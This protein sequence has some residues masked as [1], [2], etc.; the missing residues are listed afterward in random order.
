MNWFVIFVLIT[1]LENLEYPNCT[2]ESFVRRKEKN[3]TIIKEVKERLLYNLTTCALV[4]HVSRRSQKGPS[5]AQQ[6][7]MA[8]TET[9]TNKFVF[10]NLSCSWR[11]NKYFNVNTGIIKIKIWDFV[12]VFVV[13]NVA[14]YVLWRVKT[15]INIINLKN[16]CIL[17]PWFW[18]LI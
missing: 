15:L 17:K 3:S 16:V 4:I 11:T 12:D 18:R 9:F 14:I 1:N 5:I 7:I 6:I 10:R 13:E 2:L 8:F